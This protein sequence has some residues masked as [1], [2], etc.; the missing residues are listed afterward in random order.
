MKGDSAKQIRASYQQNPNPIPNP[1]KRAK[2]A[3][4]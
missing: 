3:S 4:T 1:T 2:N